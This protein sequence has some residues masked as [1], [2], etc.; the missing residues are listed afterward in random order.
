MLGR[1]HQRCTCR[2]LQRHIQ[3]ARTHLHGRR[4]PKCIARDDHALHAGAVEL[5]QRV[6]AMVRKAGLDLLLILRQGHP[7]LD[8][9]QAG[10]LLTR[11]GCR[12]LGMSD[13]VAGGHPV[14]VAG[15]D[16]LHAA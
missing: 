9:M 5:G 2:Q 6:G 3:R 10:P 15:D 8:A 4:Q 16:G 14:H 13:A 12:A 1:D 7:G 11:L